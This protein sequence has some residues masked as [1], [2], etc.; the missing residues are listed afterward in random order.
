MPQPRQGN[1]RKFYIFKPPFF[2]GEISMRVWGNIEIEAPPERVWI[3]MSL[4]ENVL[5]WCITFRKYHFSSQMRGPGA[6][7]EVEE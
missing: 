4:P 7:L 1:D 6:N 3:F 2:L 5:K